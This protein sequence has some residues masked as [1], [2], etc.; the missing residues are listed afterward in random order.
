[1]LLFQK[2][3][4]VY[5]LKKV[6]RRIFHNLTWAPI[7]F[8]GIV[9]V[10]LGITWLVHPEPWLLDKVPNEVL[11]KTSFDILFSKSININL[12][13]YLLVIYR[14]FGLWLL[15]IGSLIIIYIYV[16][17]LGTKVARNSIFLVLTIILIGIY[18]LVLNY[19]PSSPLLPVL[20]ILTLCLFC[21]MYFSRKLSDKTI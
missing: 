3:H 16:T 6:N 17:R 4:L 12:P 14:F 19:I 15:S 2:D 21:S 13:D 7:F 1:M 8:V 20:Y 5:K 11:L 18:Y 9:A 10:I